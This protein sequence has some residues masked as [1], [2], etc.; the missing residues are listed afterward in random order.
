M[1]LGTFLLTVVFDLTV[2][3][4]VG[5]VLACVLLHLPHEHAVHASQP[6]AARRA[7][8]PGV[9]V[10]ELYGSLFF[11]AVGKIEALA[12]AAARRHARAWCWRCTA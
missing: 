5:L 6:H 9:Q 7:L 12:G 2:A 8:P 10:F 4:E 11:G 1:L 3:V